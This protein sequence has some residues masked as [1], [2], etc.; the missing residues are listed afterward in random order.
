MLP[1]L[2]LLAGLVCAGLGGELFVQ[3]S[4]GLAT[5]ARISPAIVGATLAAFATS[6]PELAVSV[7]AAW[8]QQPQIALGDALGSNVVNVALILG[9]ALFISGIQASRGSLQRN[10]PLALAVPALTALLFLDGRLSRFEGGLLLGLFGVWLL[11]TVR[12]ARRQRGLDAPVRGAPSWCGIVAGG[13]LGLA[14][15]VGAGQLIVFGARA[16][17]LSWGLSEFAIGTTVVAMGTSMPELATALVAKLRGHD[18]VGLGAIVGSNLFNG[19]FIVGVAALI[20]PI[21]V[22]LSELLSSLLFGVLAL[23]LVLPNRRGWIAR[24]RGPLLL[25]LFATYLAAMLQRGG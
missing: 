12:A 13:V 22:P 3:S 10:L 25:L 8:A 24:G 7:S 9:L 15:L 23:I 5:R 16:I 20:H 11:A 1:L 4:M 19:L 17:A 21:S 18:E 2:A 14:L 6:S